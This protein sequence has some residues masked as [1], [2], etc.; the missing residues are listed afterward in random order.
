MEPRH[1]GIELNVTT[2]E[3]IALRSQ[4]SLLRGSKT[5]EHQAEPRFPILI[6]AHLES[7]CSN[8]GGE[9]GTN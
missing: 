4:Q 1:A 8:L 9:E 3:G 7:C 2:L 5:S 6:K